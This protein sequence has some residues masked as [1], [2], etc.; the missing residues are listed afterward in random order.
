MARLPLPMALLAGLCATMSGAHAAD[1]VTPVLNPEPASGW[2]VSLG[3]S[4]QIG[5]KYDGA[6][7]AGLS[8]MPSISWRRAGEDAGFSSPDDGLDYALYETKTFSFGP[9]ASF[10]SGRYSGTDVKLNGLRDVPWTIEAGAFA[11]FWPIQDRLRTRIE[12][13]QGFHGHHGVVAD[14]SVDWVEKFGAFTLSGGPR[15]SLGDKAFMRKNFGVS[16][17][18]AAANGWLTAYRPQGGLKS[19]G[20][21]AALDYEWSQS[22][23]TTTFVKYERLLDSADTSPIVR[24]LGQRDQV[25]FGLGATYSFKVGG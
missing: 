3:G 13:R 10:R 1:P 4:S 22:W 17:G 14:L 8:G 12:I 2:I 5:P 9:V 15:L 18:E 24:V 25:T 19:A 6:S 21:G 7:K 20:V 16:A 23:T 11:E